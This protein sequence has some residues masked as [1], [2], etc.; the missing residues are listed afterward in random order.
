MTAKTASIVVNLVTLQKTATN[1]KKK[2]GTEEVMVTEKK[3]WFALTVMKYAEISLKTVQNPQKEETTIVADVMA[4]MI[5]AVVIDPQKD[6][7]IVTKLDTLPEN[8][9]HQGVIGAIEIDVTEEEADLGVTIVEEGET[10]DQEAEIEGEDLLPEVTQEIEEEAIEEAVDL[11]GGIEENL[12]A[13]VQ[14]VIDVQKVEAELQALK[15][16]QDAKITKTIELD[17]R[18]T[19]PVTQIKIENAMITKVRIEEKVDRD[20][21]DLEITLEVDQKE[22]TVEVV[23]IVTNVDN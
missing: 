6:V 8:V 19:R 9:N 21:E 3:T 11:I 10:L 2:K 16:L 14:E 17:Q 20:L 4:Q 5:D 7:L 12:L 22:E 13:H 18:A 15:V 1:L 23:Q